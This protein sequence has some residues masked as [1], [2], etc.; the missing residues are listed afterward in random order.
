[1][2]NF[3]LILLRIVNF[4]NQT[5][6]IVFYKVKSVLLNHVLPSQ[7]NTNSSVTGD[8][9]WFCS[10]WGNLQIFSGREGQLQRKSAGMSWN[11]IWYA[12]LGISWILA[13]RTPISQFICFIDSYIYA[14]NNHS[15]ITLFFI[16]ASWLCI[17]FVYPS[18]LLT[19]SWI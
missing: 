12:T 17:V 9:W 5:G 18:V 4:S 6:T 3:T 15:I 8:Y 1:M 16:G 10:M 19:P 13:S 14:K 2:Q 7:Y 11:C